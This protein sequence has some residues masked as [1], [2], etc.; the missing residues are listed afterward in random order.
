MIGNNTKER[1]LEAA[2]ESISLRGYHATSIT[3]LTK[4]VGIGKSAFFYH[5]KSK[6]AL[7]ECLIRNAIKDDLVCMLEYWLKMMLM[8]LL[9]RH[10]FSDNIVSLMR[11]YHINIITTLAH[12]RRSTLFNIQN[13]LYSDLIANQIADLVLDDYEGINA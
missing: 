9:T 7:L 12:S 2:R 10:T 5:F 6:E 11:E 8:L 4:E 1:L 3:N 13:D